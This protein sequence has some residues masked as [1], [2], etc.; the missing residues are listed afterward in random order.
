MPTNPQPQP[1]VSPYERAWIMHLEQVL[2]Q[3]VWDTLPDLTPPVFA[4][5]PP[6]RWP[7]ELR[8]FLAPY[9]DTHDCHR[10]V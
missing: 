8:S 10:P 5:I 1:A 4:R 6:S 7:Q 3:R 2:P 9:V